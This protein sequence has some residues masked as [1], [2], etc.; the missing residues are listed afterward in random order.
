MR[1]I[2]NIGDVV[3]LNEKGVEYHLNELKA[4]G[5]EAARCWKEHIELK[6]S[7]SWPLQILVAN[8]LRLEMTIVNWVSDHDH[9]AVIA[10]L[11]N[12]DWGNRQGFSFDG[13]PIKTWKI[14]RSYLVLNKSGNTISLYELN[15]DLNLEE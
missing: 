14:P 4:Y 9:T 6:S 3:L 10:I 8:K 5:R 12:P 13:R 15:K 11:E 2:F 7:M 1:E